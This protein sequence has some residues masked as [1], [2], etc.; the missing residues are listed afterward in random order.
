MRERLAHGN[1][2]SIM[3]QKK[4]KYVII[5]CACM[6]AVVTSL[7]VAAL[8]YARGDHGANLARMKG[9][10]ATSDST[11]NEELSAY[12]AID[13]DAEDRSSRWSSEN[14]REDASHYIELEFPEE[15]SVSFVVLKWERRNVISYA[16]EGSVDGVSWETLASFDK[17]PERKNQEI[18]LAEAAQVR[19]LR[20]STYDVSRNA[21]DYSDIYQ[22]VSI[23]EFEVYADKP[24]AYLLGE[25]AVGYGA[26]GSRFLVMPEAPEGYEVAYLG[27]DY[28]QIIGADGVVYDTIQEKEVTVGFRLTGLD[29]SSDIQ[30]VSRTLMVPAYDSMEEAAGEVRTAEEEERRV[31]DCPEVIPALAEWRG[32]QGRFE[33]GDSF[34]I[35]VEK[36]SALREVA[37]LFR[38]QYKE[39]C[40][41]IVE[42]TEGSSADAK[43]GDF[44]LGY[45]D[46][47][48]GLRKEGYTCDISDICV[49]SAETD[50]GVRWGTVTVLQILAREGS[51]PEGQIRDYPLYE[52]R[53][54]GID[55][56]RKAV[57]MDMLYAMMEKL[58]FYKMND[59]GIH[60]NDN[61]ILSTSGLT[62]S[63]E[64]AMMADSAFRLE[65]DLVNDAGGRLTSDEYHYTKEEFA[66]F[67]DTAKTYGV[68]VVPEIDTPAHSLAITRLYPEYALTARPESVDQID[69]DQEE[70]VALVQSIWREA[71]TGE[72]AAFRD[73]D[74]VN[75]GMDEY[76]GD[77]EQYRVYAADMADMVRGEGKTVRMWGSLSHMGGKTMPDPANLQMNLWSTLWADPEQMYEAGYALINM[78]NNHLYIIPGGGY[79]YLDGEELYTQWEPYQFYDHDT[80][81]ILPR[82]SQ[83]VLG[84]AYMIW[85]DMS[86]N[87]DL[88][89]SEYDLYAR[90]AAP[91]Q[92]L[93]AKLWGMEGYR[94]GLDSVEVGEQKPGAD[95]PMES[96]ED[97]CERARFCERQRY[98]IEGETNR[99][100]DEAVGIEPSYEIEMRIYLEETDAQTALGQPADGGKTAEAQA[101]SPEAAGEVQ[102]IAESDCAYGTWAFYAVEPETGRVGFARE[103]RTYTWDYVLP[104]GQ[105]VTLK[106]AGE[107][108]QTTLY[109]DGVEIGTLGNTKPFEEYATFVFP[110][111]RVGEATG[112]FRGEIEIKRIR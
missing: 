8:L 19:F 97:F 75:I 88:G 108:G 76:Y 34:R 11:E 92:V 49:I 59:L 62:E 3:D 9:V 31:N 74:I 94:G 71:L 96:Y 91:L 82:Y 98:G 17:A 53:G 13:G 38:D 39:M 40:R 111:Q 2:V 4:K 90:F 93:G 44:Y 57:S 69:L 101:T 103:G 81:S 72:N 35:V 25:A 1:R 102:V 50:I 66:R 107:P 48:H 7:G 77:G 106:A 29:D 109:A 105:W 16:L 60:L 28:E 24:A 18:A 104:R 63:T 37:E 43:P 23:Y 32:S 58:S 30:E 54:F 110:L 52:V 45:V 33:P 12:K 47:S 61:T 99:I 36:G 112:S 46:A 86:G 68:T 80:M 73:A 51:L 79:D 21:E 5:A 22:N 15:I 65:S 56:A 84:A 27:A 89:I 83:Q 87:L 14:D 26:D 70:A 64:Q 67:I 41:C 78:Q 20:L 95:V 85:N 100:Y 42:V 6:L 55:V 10:I